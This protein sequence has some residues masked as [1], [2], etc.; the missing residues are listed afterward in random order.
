MVVLWT[1]IALG[2]CIAPSPSELPAIDRTSTV[3]SSS[4]DTEQPTTDESPSSESVAQIE[5]EIRI[6]KVE[7]GGIYHLNGELRSG[8]GENLGFIVFTTPGGECTVGIW[9][10]LQG[11]FRDRVVTDFKH[12]EGAR[13]R[14]IGDDFIR[15]EP[16]QSLE[17]VFSIQ[18]GEDA[19]KLAGLV[20][21]DREG[22]LL[23][24]LQEDRAIP[25]GF[26]LAGQA[27][28][29]SGAIELWSEKEDG[30]LV[31]LVGERKQ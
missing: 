11:D 20:Y 22:T 2:G 28:T 14:V 21:V 16:Q 6:E 3:E 26:E 4:H 27:G 7:P 18:T 15:I 1:I 31:D 9:S 30:V 12:F 10:S 8:A 24:T 13:L 23:V 5:D 19:I 25:E 29:S 17:E